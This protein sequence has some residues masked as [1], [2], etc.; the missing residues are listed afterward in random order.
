MIVTQ[1]LVLPA[2]NLTQLSINMSDVKGHGRR[3]RPDGWTL[4][5]IVSCL[6]PKEDPRTS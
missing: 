6:P 4:S 5:G 1:E 3:R 2:N